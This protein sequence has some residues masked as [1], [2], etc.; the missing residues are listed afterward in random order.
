ME[1]LRILKDEVLKWT[2][3]I[4]F[5]WTH[6]TRYRTPGIEYSGAKKKMKVLKYRSKILIVDREGG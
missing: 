4:D 1:K 5:R 2:R 3:T 6:S